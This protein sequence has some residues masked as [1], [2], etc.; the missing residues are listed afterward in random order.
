LSDFEVI[1]GV[2]EVFNGIFEVFYG[3]F[4]S[5]MG[6]F[7]SKMGVFR[8]QRRQIVR[9]SQFYPILSRFSAFLGD[10]EMF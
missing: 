4:H 2:F 9:G 3:I 5:T 7:D 1:Y 8:V 6:A 10:F